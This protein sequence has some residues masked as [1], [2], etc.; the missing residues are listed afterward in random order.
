[1]TGWMGFGFQSGRSFDISNIPRQVKGVK[2]CQFTL[3]GFRVLCMHAC[4]HSVSIR[5][6]VISIRSKLLAIDGHNAIVPII[7]TSR[8]SQNQLRTCCRSNIN[9]SILHHLYTRDET[10]LTAMKPITHNPLRR[11]SQTDLNTP[12]VVPCTG[13]C[14]SPICPIPYPHT[15]GRYRHLGLGPPSNV[16]SYPFGTSNPPPDSMKRGKGC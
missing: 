7:G 11:I 15:A 6:T 9:E 5:K 10:P 16:Y 3:A 12:Y 8:L 2:M 13:R 1:M 14:T 4:L